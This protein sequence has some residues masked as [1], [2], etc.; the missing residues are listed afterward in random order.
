MSAPAA[1]RM[2]SMIIISVGKRKSPTAL[3]ELEQWLQHV[4]PTS[5]LSCEH[6]LVL[7]YE[8][9]FIQMSLAN[10]TGVSIKNR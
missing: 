1:Q 2:I 7:A 8:N 10:T 3:L 4:P 5:V 9:N 6:K